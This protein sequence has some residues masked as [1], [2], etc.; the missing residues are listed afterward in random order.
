MA[1]AKWPHLADIIFKRICVMKFFILIQIWRKSVPW[2]LV[3]NKPASVQTISWNPS[4]N[5]QLSELKRGKITD[6]YVCHRVSMCVDLNNIAQSAQ[7]SC[8]FPIVMVS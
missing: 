2:C 7:D 6:A 8:S 4:G 1:E 3:N 5:K